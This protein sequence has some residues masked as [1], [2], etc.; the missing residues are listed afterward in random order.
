MKPWMPACPSRI[1][2]S[3]TPHRQGRMY[4]IPPGGPI[5]IPKIYDGHDKTFFFFSFEQFR[6]SAVTSTTVGIVPTALQRTGDFAAA[7]NGTCNG[8]DP[9]GQ[10]VCLNQIFDPSSNHT[11]GGSVVRN[12]FGGNKIPLTSIDPTAQII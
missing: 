12:P 7:L 6:Q 2:A 8:P 4:G 10:Q 11:V 9:A 3:R 5:K 1:R